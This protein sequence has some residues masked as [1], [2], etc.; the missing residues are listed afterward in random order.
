[1]YPLKK[2][3]AAIGLGIAV[4]AAGAQLMSPAKADVVSFDQA[5]PSG[6]LCPVLDDVEITAIDFENFFGLGI[7]FGQNAT[8][9]KPLTA[10]FEQQGGT[11]NE[12]NWGFISDQLSAGLGAGQPRI[13][14][15]ITGEANSIFQCYMRF[16]NEFFATPTAQSN[17]F[18][19]IDYGPFNPVFDLS[20]DLLD[21]DG[22]STTATEQVI[23]RIIDDN[24]NIVDEVDIT[25]SSNSAGSGDSSRTTITLAIGGASISEVQFHWQ[26]NKTSGFGF[27]I[28]NFETGI[29]GALASFRLGPVQGTVVPV[30]PSILMAPAA[31][32]AAG[33]WL[34][35]RRAAPPPA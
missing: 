34:R 19:T 27:G 32:V 11:T 31:L 17:P 7:R 29:P 5:G 13:T 16:G 2:H 4:A 3:F 6:L 35:R 18:M 14:D 12:A 28:D 8:T 20:F 21:L 1:M 22:V 25:Q 26:G 15:S 24:N 9:G 10:Y 33:L 30:P 23:V